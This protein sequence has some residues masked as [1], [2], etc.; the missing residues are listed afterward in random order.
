MQRFKAVREDKKTRI[1]NDFIYGAAS[2]SSSAIWEK[3]QYVIQ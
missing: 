2:V 3:V 1:I